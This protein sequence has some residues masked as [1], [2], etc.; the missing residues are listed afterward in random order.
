MMNLARFEMSS[1]FNELFELNFD[2]NFLVRRKTTLRDCMCL[3]ST[4]DLLL[5]VGTGSVQT[6]PVGT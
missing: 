6:P 5:Q 1:I 4:V 3:E 2:K